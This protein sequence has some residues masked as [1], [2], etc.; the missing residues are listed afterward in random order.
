MLYKSGSQ[1][2]ARQFCP[3]GHIWQ[4]PEILGGGV[5]R[6]GGDM[7]ATT[8]YWIDAR[9]AARHPSTNKMHTP[10]THTHRLPPCKHTDAQPRMSWPSVPVGPKLRKPCIIDKVVPAKIILIQQNLS[11]GLRLF[12]YF[13][14]SCHPRSRS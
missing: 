1:R 14:F 9:D 2:G 10:P 7:I 3:S 4:L 6:G 8:I 12:H 5:K 11:I 13:N